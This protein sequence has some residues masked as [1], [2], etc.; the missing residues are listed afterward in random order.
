MRKL[1]SNPRIDLGLDPPGSVRGK[2][3]SL[4]NIHHRKATSSKH[5]RTILLNFRIDFSLLRLSSTAQVD[6]RDPACRLFGNS[7]LPRHDT[8]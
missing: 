3:D 2:S 8:D 7:D 1:T 5:Q 6:L 4:C